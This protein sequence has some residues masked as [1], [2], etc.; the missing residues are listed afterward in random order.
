MTVIE[1]IGRTPEEKGHH[2]LQLSL[3]ALKELAALLEDQRLSASD[4]AV[5]DEAYKTNIDSYDD[6]VCLRD[7]ILAQKKSFRRFILNLFVRETDVQRYH[8]ITYRNYAAIK[9]TSDD[10]SR[11][12]LTNK[13]LG[14]LRGFTQGHATIYEESPHDVVEGGLPVTDPPPNETIRGIYIDAHGEQEEQEVLETVNRLKNLG[15]EDKDDDDDD[16]DDVDDDDDQTIRPPRSQSRPPS[17]IPSF[18]ITYNNYNINQSVVS[19]DSE[20]NGT[21]LNIGVDG[22]V[23]SSSS[24]HTDTNQPLS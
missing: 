14:T 20:S 3:T 1:M 22:G 15:G 23:A 2:Y 17:P 4:K 5:Y 10:L 19:I 18:T 6:M 21:T 12:L 11:R 7:R 16:V 9:R 8:K 24:Q 13:N